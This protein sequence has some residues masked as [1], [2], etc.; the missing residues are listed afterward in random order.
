MALDKAAADEAAADEAATIDSLRAA[1]QRATGIRFAGG[2]D[3][4]KSHV[5]GMAADYR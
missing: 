1:R 4:A 3:G 5:T 2:C